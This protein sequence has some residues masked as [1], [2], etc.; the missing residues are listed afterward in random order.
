MS[1]IQRL[2]RE[3]VRRRLAGLL[4]ALSAAMA[5]PC[6]AQQPGTGRPAAGMRAYPT[7]YYV[8]YTDLGPEK[9]REAAARMT[10][11]G[12]EYQKRTS[13]FA[14]HVRERLPFYL[15]SKAEDYHAA[16]GPTG[17]AGVYMG[18]KLMAVAGARLSDNAWRVIQHEGFH[19]YVDRAISRRIPV[20]VNEGMA[21]YFG[22][23][24]WTGDSYVVGVIPPGRL[25]SLK[26]LI[27]KGQIAPFLEMLEMSY[28]QWSSNLA[29][30][31][32]AQAWAM[33]HFLAHADGERYQGAFNGFI[34][35]IAGGGIGWQDAFVRRFGRDVAGF[36]KRFCDWWASLPDNPTADLYNGAVVLTLTSFLARA[37]GQGQRFEDVEEFFKAADEGKLKEDPRQWLPRELL[38]GRLKEARK[39]REWKL[40]NTKGV[41]TLQLA[42]PDGTTLTGAFRISPGSQVSVRVD[43]NRG[44]K[45]P[46]KDGPVSPTRPGESK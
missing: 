6:A 42:M 30:R 4:A 3:A 34:T 45:P 35:D 43:V 26:S 1:A 39:L 9:V 29:G 38:L 20:W 13:G 40:L 46:E 44:R 23:G 27:K 15:F 25:R 41:P 21:E 2:N 19:Q 32:Y 5:A 12:L 31:N 17:S 24:V 8:I 22:H 14:R 7:P 10:C 18:N 37:Y 28:K 16:G 36:E 33:V 11:M